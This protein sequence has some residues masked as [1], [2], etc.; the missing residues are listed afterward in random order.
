MFRS[1]TRA[2]E[3]LRPSREEIAAKPLAAPGPPIEISGFR[4]TVDDVPDRRP[5]PMGL[6]SKSRNHW[7]RNIAQIRRSF[8][9]PTASGRDSR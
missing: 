3:W 9:C 8:A 2:T 6:K 1:C 5:G 4:E 7:D